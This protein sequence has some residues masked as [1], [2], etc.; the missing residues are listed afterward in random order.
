MSGKDLIDFAVVGTR[1]FAADE[2]AGVFLSTDEGSTWTSVNKGL[3][4]LQVHAFAQ[5]ETFLF[6]STD[7][8]IFLTTDNGANWSSIRHNLPFLTAGALE[9]YD[10]NLYAGIFRLEDAS[11]SHGAWRTSLS[12]VVASVLQMSG[13]TPEQFG[14]MQNYPNPFNPSTKI[15]FKLQASGFTSL[16]IFDLLGR[17]VA[18]LVNE[19][20]RPGSYEAPW[21]ASGFPSGIYFYTL[22]SGEFTETKKLV[23]VK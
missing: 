18:T 15:G 17:E 14:L 4:S 8:G 7:Q 13:E 23:L 9:I 1:L 16:R 3:T 22:T 21:D 11:V 20:L 5:S 10:G 19:E 12:G 2:G 6:A